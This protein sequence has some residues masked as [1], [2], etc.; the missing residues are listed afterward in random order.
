LL[1]KWPIRNKLL[2]GLAL[3]LVIVLTLSWSAFYGLYAYR[4]LVKSLERVE[5]LRL[6]SDFNQK[7]SDLRVIVSKISVLSPLELE[8]STYN[9]R[10]LRQEFRQDLSD[11][12][13]SLGAYKAKLERYD[14]PKNQIADSQHEWEAVQ[15]IENSLAGIDRLHNDADWILDQDKL[16]LLKAE[17][18]QLH[19]LSGQLPGYLHRNIHNFTDDVRNQRRTFIT[20]AWTCTVAALV[21]MVCFVRLFYKWVFRP[22]RLL[23]KGSRKVAAGDFYHR[24]RLDTRDEMSELADALNDMTA[25]FQAIRDDLDRQVQERTRQVIR[26][27]KLASVGFLA[28]GVA[29]EINNPL[30]SIAMCAES[31]E[32]R[33]VSLIDEAHPDYSTIRSYLRMI[34][35]EAFRCK[36]IT[37]KLLDFSRMGDV[38][39]QPT[40]LRDLV[41]GVLDMLGHLG[42]YQRKRIEFVPGEP[43]VA[44]VNA[45]EIKQVVLNLLTN[46]LESTEDDGHV[47]VEL[48]HHAGQ[49]KLVVSDDGCGMTDE[50]LEHLFEPFFTRRRHGQGTGLGLSIS[51]RIIEEHGGQIEAASDGPGRGSRFRVW[52]PLVAESMSEKET[53]H[54]YQAA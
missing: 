47:I 3:L 2:I 46:A 22:L 10:S 20:L 4:G 45:Q 54:R 37:G 23:I 52:L 11:V 14:Y 33:T 17:L 7:V 12:K 51:Y 43:V 21:M 30:A 44:A 53:N 15:Q 19:D 50:V 49:A 38:K 34:Q 8:L 24:I 41:Q 31:L 25:R 18:E 16:R 28:A 35:D 1:S 29:H 48:D 39:R 40:E 6:A 26:S 9:L 36:E 13:Q 27:E 42:K 5:E 32:G